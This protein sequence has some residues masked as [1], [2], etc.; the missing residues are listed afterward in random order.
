MRNIYRKLLVLI[1]AV[2]ASLPACA[3]DGQTFFGF[4]IDELLRSD[5]HSYKF[6]FVKFNTNDTTNVEIVKDAGNVYNP[7]MMAGEYF[8][9][10]I[11][12][13][14]FKW[15]EYFEEQYAYSYDVYDAKT[16]ERLS[17]VSKSYVT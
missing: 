11:Y 9:G 6:G 13:Y 2:V 4:Q 1:V 16:F 3:D 17:R 7:L 14:M 8:D 5:D 10:K 15:D 12:C